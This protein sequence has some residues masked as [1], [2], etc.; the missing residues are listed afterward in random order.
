MIKHVANQVFLRVEDDDSSFLP[1]GEH[2]WALLFHDVNK[3]RLIL[4]HECQCS[5]AL[6]VCVDKSFFQAAESDLLFIIEVDQLV[7]DFSVYL[8]DTLKVIFVFLEKHIVIVHGS[9]MDPNNIA[10]FKRMIVKIVF[11]L[12]FGVVAGMTND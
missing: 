5:I 11:R 6:Q 7:D 2:H 8:T 10:D 1:V 3:V 4:V 9:V 12:A